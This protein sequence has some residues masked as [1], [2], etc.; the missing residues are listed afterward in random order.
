MTKDVDNYEKGV[1]GSESLLKEKSLPKDILIREH[2]PHCKDKGTTKERIAI[3]ED[4]NE[5][6][7]S[8]GHRGL[9]L[10]RSLTAMKVA[11]VQ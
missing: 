10:R 4:L 7:P 8:K 1:N 11:D 9:P 3:R 5:E 6:T 2:H